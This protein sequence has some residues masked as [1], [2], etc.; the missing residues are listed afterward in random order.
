MQSN[1]KD[2]NGHANPLMLLANVAR[3]PLIGNQPD[4]GIG[5]TGAR[6]RRAAPPPRAARP[7]GGRFCPAAPRP[8]LSVRDFWLSR[9][10]Q[11]RV[12][13]WA[14]AGSGT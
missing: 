6:P 5:G 9:E 2:A 3:G 10:F 1:A 12:Q 4:Q 11:N 7:P 13:T 8:G 14:T